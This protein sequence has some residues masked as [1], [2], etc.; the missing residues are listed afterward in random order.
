MSDAYIYD[1]IRTPFGRQGGVLANMR[2]DNLLA[3][4]IKSLV[5]SN[6]ING[7]LLEDVIAGNTNQAGED[8]RNIARNAALLS[9]LPLSVA[10]ISVNRLC[11]SGVSA[12][13]DAARAVRC[14]EG[15]LFVA[16][17]IESMSRAPW[18]IGKAESAYSRDQKMFDSTLGWRFP[19][20][21]LTGIYGAE[22]NT[23]TAENIATDIG[24]TEI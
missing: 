2:P 19:N 23:E 1:G 13:L 8:S 6:S 9:G 15:E 21:S 17:G 12:V 5:E 24:I 22:S 18:V 7:E 11:G 10:G 3:L 20:K 4:V 16:C 14:N